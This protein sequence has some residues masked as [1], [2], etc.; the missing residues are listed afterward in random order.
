MNDA[1]ALSRVVRIIDVSEGMRP[2]YVH[3]V[4]LVERRGLRGT[5]LTS[6]TKIYCEGVRS[7]RAGTD[8]CFGFPAR[9][10]WSVGLSERTKML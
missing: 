10:S 8:A 4:P 2:V 5:P 3:G 7:V 6:T 1:D 9:T